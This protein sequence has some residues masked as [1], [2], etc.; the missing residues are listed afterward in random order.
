MNST[1]TNGAGFVRVV[2]DGVVACNGWLKIVLY[3]SVELN[4]SFN[5]GVAKTVS[6]FCICLCVRFKVTDSLALAHSL[7]LLGPRLL[8]VV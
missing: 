1:Q 5:D 8:E 7:N 3:L 2:I 6:A 4:L